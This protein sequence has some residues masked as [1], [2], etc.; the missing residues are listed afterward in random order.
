MKYEKRDLKVGDVVAAGRLHRNGSIVR[1][2]TGIVTKINSRGHIY[3]KANDK[4]TRVFNKNLIE[5][6]SAVTNR[7]SYL[8]DVKWFNAQ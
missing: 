4:P 2:M 6:H 5:R 8:L 3:V 1:K 7:P